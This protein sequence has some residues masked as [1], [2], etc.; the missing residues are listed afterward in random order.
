M[1]RNI[2]Q[3]SGVR[4]KFRFKNKMFSIDASTI[5]LC[6]SVFDWAKFRR[7]KGRGPHGQVSRLWG[8]TGPSSCT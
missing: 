6:A 5:E 3:Q 4:H 7:T 8:G 2:A 1:G